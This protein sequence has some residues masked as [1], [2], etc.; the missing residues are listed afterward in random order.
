MQSADQIIAESKP[1]VVLYSVMAS[2]LEGICREMTHTLLR[3]ARSPVLALA[4]DFSCTIVSGDNEWLMA[5]DGLPIMVGGAPQA[6]A[7]MM[8]CHAKLSAGDAFIHNDPYHANTHSGDLT[9]LVPVLVAGEHLF[10]VVV[11]GHQADIGNALPTTYMAAA[12]DVFEEGA[13]VFPCVQVQRDYEDVSDIIRMAFSRIRSPEVWYGDYL[14]MVGAARIGERS[15]MDLAE[16]YG[17]LTVTG[18]VEWWLNYGERR[19]AQ[20][21][22]QLKS[23]VWLGQ[24]VHD[25][26]GGIDEIPLTVEVTVDSAEGTIDVN[27]VNNPD[28][29]PFGLNQSETTATAA[30][31]VGVFNCLDPR[32]PKNSG[33]LRRI[34]VRLRENCVA[35]IPR[36]P[37]S[38]SVATTNIA[39]RIVNMVQTAFAEMGSDFGMAEGA[40]SLGPDRPNV[41]GKDPRANN[42]DYAVQLFIGTQGG[43]ATSST[44]GWLAYVLPVAAGVL[45]K[46]SVEATE[47]KLPILI[48]ENRVRDNCEGPGR[49]RGA[50]GNELMYGPVGAPMDVYYVLDGVEHPPKGVQGGWNGVGPRVYRLTRDGTRVDETHRDG[51]V[52]LED[53]EFLIAA[54]CGGAGHGS[55][56]EREASQVLHDVRE[57]YVSVERALEVYGVVIH[58]DAD[59]PES[60][61]VALQ[62]TEDARER[63]RRSSRL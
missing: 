8:E 23:G 62:Q 14:A 60:L 16:K 10:T 15:L 34:T 57:R 58:G 61:E 4:H 21:I 41:S 48:L 22:G 50:P 2:R 9:I 19:T 47:H 26:I 35:G 44:D 5:A 49:F 59:V 51:Y 1:D 40:V 3:T 37:A 24:T 45:H 56:I 12:K 46:N 32:I 6:A 36:Y 29:L 31:L 53:G 20:A 11:R 27:L 17:S 42:R 55:P 30:A 25:P 13:V 54:S 33:S 38:C 52:P 63:L 43:P 28:C 39:D 18:F 7:Y